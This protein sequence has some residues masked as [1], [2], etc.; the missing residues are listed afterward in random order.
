MALA[1]TALDHADFVS[2]ATRQKIHD[3]TDKSGG[4]TA[5]QRAAFASSKGV[6]NVTKYWPVDVVLAACSLWGIEPVLTKTGNRRAYIHGGLSYAGNAKP[7][8][9]TTA[10]APTPAPAPAAKAFDVNTITST[11]T[12]GRDP[13]F[14]PPVT[15]GGGGGATF[16]PAEQPQQAPKQ[17]QPQPLGT[18]AT[19]QDADA[20]RQRKLEAL[21]GRIDQRVA[22]AMQAAQVADAEALRTTI[23][24]TSGAAAIAVV[25]TAGKDLLEKLQQQAAAMLQVVEQRAE[26]RLEQA[27][28]LIDEARPVE[29][30]V[31]HRGGDREE[32]VS[33]PGMQHVAFQFVLRCLTAGQNVML[34][35]PAG[36]GKTVMA[37]HLADALTGGRF[38][39][40][41]CTEDMLAS[42]YRGRVQPVTDTNG[43]TRWEYVPAPFV[44][45]FENGGVFLNDEMDRGNPN[46]LLTL[47]TALDNGYFG[48]PE[49]WHAPMATKSEQF[50]FLGSA[51][52][53]GKG[54]NHEYVGANQLDSAT[55]DRFVVV[56]MDFDRKLEQSL[57][58][59]F[60]ATVGQQRI[61]AVLQR[62]WAVRER[63]NQHRLRRNVGTRFVVRA[64]KMLEGGFSEDQIFSTLAA[65]WSADECRKADLQQT[66]LF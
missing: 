43:I 6:R 49:R 26:E 25:E 46:T 56:E 37:K 51:N 50:Y 62:A 33:L 35:G 31:Q 15:V 38:D 28:A 12:T 60:Y 53:Y 39:A 63:I 59:G 61:E 5:R 24:T 47:N 44:S 19:A 21:D 4:P 23:A 57:A 66:P 64:C 11:N 27:V 42:I 14:K 54:A 32:D 48:L 10:A 18:A 3:L 58:R 7:G 36:C 17:P 8:T 65:G 34:V 2:T 13:Y 9:T 1:V 20:E 45:L 55:L 40:V 52:T 29:V 22:A 41:N 16:A 30:V